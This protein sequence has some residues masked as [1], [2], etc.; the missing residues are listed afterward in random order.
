MHKTTN[1]QRLPPIIS[2]NTIHN[3][4]KQKQPGKSNSTPQK[5][6]KQHMPCVEIVLTL[7]VLEEY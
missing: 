4:K 3:L 7:L 1:T 5:V 6:Q 2:K